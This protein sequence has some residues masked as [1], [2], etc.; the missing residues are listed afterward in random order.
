MAV[1]PI[2]PEPLPGE[3]LIPKP[4]KRPSPLRKILIRVG[5]VLILILLFWFNYW[6]FSQ[7]GLSIEDIFPSREEPPKEEEKEPEEP[8]EKPEIVIPS[9]LILVEDT[10]TFV[11]S[12]VEYTQKLVTFNHKVLT[13][14]NHC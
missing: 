14:L 1:K 10:L 9:S 5:V 13:M 4:P 7:K 2:K 11:I 12:G 8:S 3:T 6:F